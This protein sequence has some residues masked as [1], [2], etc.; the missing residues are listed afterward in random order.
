MVLIIIIHKADECNSRIMIQNITV[1][2][3][4]IVCSYHT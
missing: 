3:T 4:T 1:F 2:S